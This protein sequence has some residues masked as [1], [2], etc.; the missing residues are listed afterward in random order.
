[1]VGL[2]HGPSHADEPED[3]AVSARHARIGR[4]L[5][6]IYLVFYIGYMLLTAFRLDVMRQ[7]YGG[8][9]LAILYGFGLILGAFVLAM[10]YGWL[11]RSLKE[12]S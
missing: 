12:P 7:S 2:D 1:M 6:A 4:L 9:N 11:C 3:L 8:V 10:I 5:F